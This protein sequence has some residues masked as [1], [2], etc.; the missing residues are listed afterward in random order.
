MAALAKGHPDAM[1]MLYDRY[2]R[3]VFSFALRILGN[4]EQ[5]EELLQEVYL[6]AWRRAA[7][8]TDGRGSLIS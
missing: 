4:R 3:P 8:F 6:R 7:R 1:S 5:A 2:H